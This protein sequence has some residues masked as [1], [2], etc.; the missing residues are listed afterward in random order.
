LTFADETSVLAASANSS[1]S[2]RKQLVFRGR[3]CNLETG[4]KI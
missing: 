1:D 2:C 3:Y 4:E